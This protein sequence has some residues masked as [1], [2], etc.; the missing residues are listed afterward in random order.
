MNCPDIRR[1]SPE[2]GG[3]GERGELPAQRG[4]RARAPGAG[5]GAPAGPPAGAAGRRAAG[6]EG[7]CLLLLI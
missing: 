2:H 4:V 3:R 6:R 7:H 5:A 1:E